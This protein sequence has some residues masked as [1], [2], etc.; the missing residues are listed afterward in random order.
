[1][2]ERGMKKEGKNREGKG[3][4]QGKKCFFFGYC[5]FM[6]KENVIRNPKPR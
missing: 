4:G 5:Y 6:F 2:D 3:W 1:M